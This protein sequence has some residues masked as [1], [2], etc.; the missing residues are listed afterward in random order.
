MP[1]E[2]ILIDE[3]ILEERYR[4]D[5]K[6][7]EGLAKSIAEN[8]LLHPV[9]VDSS[10]RL[11][12]GG[13]R[14]AAYK[15]LASGAF[16]GI[17]SADFRSVPVTRFG[18]LDEGQRKLLELEENLRRENTTW[19]EEVLGM[20]D[21]H[22]ICYKR[23][24]KRNEKWT[25][26]ATGKL[27][28]MDQGPVSAM[29]K[30]AKILKDQPEDP[31][32]DCASLTDALK[33]LLQRA[34][35]EASREQ[36]KRINAKRA[37]LD[38]DSDLSAATFTV[39]P[40]VVLNRAPILA[41]DGTPAAQEREPEIIVSNKPKL[42]TKEQVAE[43]YYHGN[44]LTLLP[45]IASKMVINHIICDPPYGIDMINLGG[46]NI[47]RIEETHEVEPNKQLL[48]E[49]L[50]VAYSCLASDGFLC[51]WYDLDHHEKLSGWAS[52][53]GFRVCRWPLIWCKSSP[54]SN[55]AS[56]YNITKSTEVC[57]VLRKSEQSVIK[58]K[59]SRNWIVAP[60][61]STNSH[62]FVKPFELWKYLIETVSVE[63][64]TI[65]DPFAGEGSS[66]AAC[67]RLQ[68]FPLG[69]EIDDKHIANGLDYVSSQMNGS[70]AE[71]VEAKS[72]VNS[73]EGIPDADIP[74]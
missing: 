23:A 13:R 53:I 63:G 8:G 44:A 46:N 24:L 15:L 30:V 11:I 34:Q 33:L 70:S 51:L 39:P 31:V 10:N 27:L 14:Y 7:L 62:P 56:H 38:R 45:K 50:N 19:Q 74:L 72:V 47:Q 71:L 40:V 17:T 65:V 18:D 29:L 60:S 66:L 48:K 5:Y 59:Q 52:E 58:T 12:A 43:L 16:N 68:R 28:N 42:I 61:A 49:F 6:D 4:K 2:T 73:L 54:C 26:E 3:I 21:Y 37:E 41:A 22:R 69:I 20:Y 64:Q 36:L 55:Q 32:K 25:Q 57:L 1:T 67:L 9:V 35:D